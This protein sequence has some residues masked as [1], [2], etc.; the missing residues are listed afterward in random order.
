[1]DAVRLTLSVLGI[2]ALLAL[3][4]PAANA[5]DPY[6]ID[7]LLPLT[8]SAAALGAEAQQTLATIEAQVN[9]DGGIDGHAL[10]FAV[11]DD[12]SSA[13][14]ALAL[15]TDLIARHVAIVLGPMSADQCRA[16]APLVHAGPVL[17]CLAPDFVPEPGS[18][19]FTAGFAPGDLLLVAVR[20]ARLRGLKRVALITATDAA[21]AEFAH[22]LDATLRLPENAG[23]TIVAREQFDPADADARAQL[24]RIKAAGTQVTIAASAGARL[25]LV[26]RSAKDMELTTPLIAGSAG[27]T[28]AEMSRYANVLPRELLFAAAPSF[29]PDEIGDKATR[30]AVATFLAAFNVQGIRP[31]IGHGLTWDAA[32]LLVAALRSAGTT[33]VTPA[34]LRAAFDRQRNWIGSNGS[35]DFARV[36]QRGLGPS[37]IVMVRWDAPNA[38]WA[39][40]SKPGGVPHPSPAPDSATTVR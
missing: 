36:P 27:L 38:T 40:V 35:Y 33:T 1:V 25:G 34:R 26:L 4:G 11:A 5:A 39:G 32:Q 3:T 29:A 17:D 23:M 10:H 22:A 31:D 19:A 30:D 2:A 6:E 9:A 18:F 16:L 7:A 24:Q 12:Q 28:Y 14:T 15:A 13:R 8:G 21:G 20:Y 37:G